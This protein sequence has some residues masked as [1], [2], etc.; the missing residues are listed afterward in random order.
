MHLA[1]TKYILRKAGA[2][3]QQVLSSKELYNHLNDFHK[4]LQ[5][6]DYSNIGN[7][8]FINLESALTYMESVKNNPFQKQYEQLQETLDILQPYLPFL[9]SSRAKDFLIHI[10]TVTDDVE[11][12]RLKVEYSQ[13]LRMDFINTAR[14]ITCQE[15][16]RLIM[17]I[18]EQIRSRKA[19]TYL[20]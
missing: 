9:S 8:R 5:G 3:M 15:D 13:K 1:N 20:H 14:K 19:E 12:E 17:A 7:I 2:Y 6:F 10:S 16:W 4:T 18:C 11:V